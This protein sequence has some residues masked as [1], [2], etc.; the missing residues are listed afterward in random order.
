MS[1][2]IRGFMHAAVAALLSETSSAL[3]LAYIILVSLE[4]ALV[5]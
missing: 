3:S 4:Y 5:L 2:N 1:S